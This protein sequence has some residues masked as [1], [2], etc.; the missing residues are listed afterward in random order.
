MP[1]KPSSNQFKKQAKKAVKKTHGGILA[2]AVIFLVLGAIIGYVGAMYITQNDCFVINGNRETYVTQGT[3]CTY[4][5]LGAT[6]ISFGRDLSESVRIEHDFPADEN[7]NFTVD[8]SV[9]KTYV[10]TY[11]IDDFKYRNVKKIRTITIVGGE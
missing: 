7:G 3:P 8:T 1:S 10:I 5:E 11:S 6:V 9:E 4:I 2:I